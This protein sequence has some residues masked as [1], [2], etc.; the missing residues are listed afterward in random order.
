[1][2]PLTLLAAQK[3]FDLLTVGNALQD[4][5]DSLASPDNVVLPVISQSQIILS[6]VDPDLGDDSVQLTYP[7]ICLYPS[8]VKNTKTEKFCSFSG[9]VSLVAEIWASGELV[10]QIDQWIHYYVEAYTT[11]LRQNAGG[12]GD[13]IYYSGVYDVQFQPPKAGGLGFVES[14]KVTCVLDV[15]R[16]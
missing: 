6:S 3:V 2:V 13:G 7:R 10:G 16:N 15:S 1:M 8:T 14:A 4:E 11:L 12:W 5:I 9:T